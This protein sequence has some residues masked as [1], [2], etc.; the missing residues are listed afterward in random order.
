MDV[1]SLSNV[2]MSTFLD[3]EIELGDITGSRSLG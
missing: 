3:G 1:Y 2:V